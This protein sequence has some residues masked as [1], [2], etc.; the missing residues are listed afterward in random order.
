VIKKNY[1]FE[2]QK[3]DAAK[4]RKQDEKRQKKLDRSAARSDAETEQS[5]GQ[6]GTPPQ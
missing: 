6:Q 2:K 4:K 5:P 3:K 1:K